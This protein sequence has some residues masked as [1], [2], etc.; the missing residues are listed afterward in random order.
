[1]RESWEKWYLSIAH[2]A[3][4]RSRDPSTKVGCVVARRNNTIVAVGYNDFPRGVLNLPERYEHRPTKYALTVHAER[5]ALDQIYEDASG[6]SI[7]CTHHPCNEC[8]KSIIQRGIAR[9]Y[10]DSNVVL[11]DSWNESVAYAKLMFDEVGIP[12][13]KV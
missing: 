7:Y 3:A 12:V 2:Q 4:S 1:M 6:H 10:I 11:P 9:V 13:I 5:N 8:A